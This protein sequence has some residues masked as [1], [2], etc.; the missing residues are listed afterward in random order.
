[1]FGDGKNLEVIIQLLP[2]SEYI[3]PSQSM[4]GFNPGGART[5]EYDR[6]LVWCEHGYTT[7]FRNIA[8]IFEVKE[9]SPEPRYFIFIDPRYS[10]QFVM[11]E[12]EAVVKIGKPEKKKRNE[13]SFDG[14]F[15]SFTINGMHFGNGDS[16]T[17]PKRKPKKKQ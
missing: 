15:V 12:I 8:G 14:Q 7:Q 4:F 13:S 17:K 11:K 9:D 6:L 2:R 3:E 10:T 1:M 5:H 16:E